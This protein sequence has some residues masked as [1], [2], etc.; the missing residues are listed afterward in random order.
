[1]MV[2]VVTIGQWL[3]SLPPGTDPSSID[4]RQRMMFEL[5]WMGWMEKEQEIK[6]IENRR[7]QL[8]KAKLQQDREAREVG[9]IVVSSYVI[10][11]TRFRRN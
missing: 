7:L 5:E 1:M 10:N 8:Y 11:R 9:D 3:A 6:D 4:K 2:M